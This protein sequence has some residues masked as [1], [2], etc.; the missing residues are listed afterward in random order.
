MSQ[1]IEK[2]K[3]DHVELSDLFREIA[4]LG[5]ASEEGREKLLEAKETLLDHLKKED[6][7]LYP[8]LWERAKHDHDLKLKLESFAN[9]MENVTKTILAFFEKYEGGKHEADF[10][11]DFGDMYLT[12]TKRINNEESSLFKEYEE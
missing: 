6:D 4:L 10:K 12:L 8:V 5:V 1:L 3:L 2:L 7:E 9:D 11:N